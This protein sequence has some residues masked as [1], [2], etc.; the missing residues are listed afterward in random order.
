METIIKKPQKSER[1]VSF[2][3]FVMGKGLKRVFLA[4]FKRY[5]NKTFMTAEEWTTLLE[6]YK[7]R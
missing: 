7:N 6:E 3:E 1:L 5:A 4:G 2:D